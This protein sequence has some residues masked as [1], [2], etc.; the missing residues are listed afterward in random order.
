[1]S[2]V[3]VD[4]SG[5]Y[6]A[7][8]L[9][10]ATGWV[11]GRTTIPRP[12]PPEAH[13]HPRRAMERLL[14]PA[15]QQRPCVVGFSG[16]RDSSAVLAVAVDLARREGLDPP[17]PVTNVYPELDETDE[18][19][20]Q[21][22]VIR[23]LGLDEWVRQEFTDETDLLSPTSIASLRRH[24]PLWPATIHNREPLISVARGGCYIDGEGGDE[25]LGDFRL[26]PLVRILTG[27]L[28]IGTRA[29]KELVKTLGPKRVRRHLARRSMRYNRTLRPW[30]KPEAN[31]WFISTSAAESTDVPLAYGPAILR[32]LGHRGVQACFGNLDRMGAHLGVQYVHPLL[33]P[34]FALALAQFGPRWGHAGRTATMR[35]VFRDLLPE[36]L[37]SRPTKVFFN[38]A[39]AHRH[40]REFVEHWDGTGLDPELIDAE[41]L[42][43][44]WQHP[45]FPG[46]SFQLVHLA[47][48]ATHAGERSGDRAPTD[49]DPTPTA[50]NA[51]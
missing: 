5:F 30:L 29:A 41:E 46:G 47:W 20:W 32:F 14:L 3:E 26:T 21:E 23:H 9:E 11:S 17:V 25:V 45:L 6:R 2:A 10:M 7:S 4:P 49:V 35:A 40:T 42:L 16:G 27:D 28:Q 22:L 36:E 18:T 15:L 1:M 39:Y 34:G 48:L 44:A 19:R 12:E 50:A 8:S 24:G 37:L 43:R 33:D 13:E 51:S 31:E 38:R